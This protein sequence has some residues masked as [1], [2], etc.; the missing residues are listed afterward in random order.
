[1]MKYRPVRFSHL[2]EPQI[3]ERVRRAQHLLE[4][5]RGS[6]LR[7]RRGLDSRDGTAIADHAKDTFAPMAM[8][9]LALP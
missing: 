3:V 2:E 8:A 7:R 4:R 5:E 9:T 1:M 6:Q